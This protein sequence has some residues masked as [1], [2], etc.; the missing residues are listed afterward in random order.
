MGGGGGVIPANNVHNIYI[1]CFAMISVHGLAVHTYRSETL[2]A[3]IQFHVI[4]MWLLQYI[5]LWRGNLDTKASPT[6]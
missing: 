3:C 2:H 6:E 5:S 4:F 1:K